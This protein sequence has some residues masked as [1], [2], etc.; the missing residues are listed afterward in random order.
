AS[1]DVE[2]APEAPGWDAETAS[3]KYTSLDDILDGPD[4]LGLLDGANT[5]IFELKHV[6][7]FADRKS[8]EAPD[9]IAQRR[10]CQDFWRYE[11]FF[12]QALSILKT[13]DVLLQRPREGQIKA[14]SLFV[15]RGQL[16][17]VDSVLEGR[18]GV[19]KNA[20]RDG[21]D[22]GENRR[23]HCV[24][25]NGTELDILTLSLAKALY[26]DK[27]SKFV[28]MA[29]NLFSEHVVSV[30]AK[31][32]PTGF[33]YVLETLSTAPEL[34]ELKARRHLVKI[35]YS[36]QPVDKRIA[37]AEKDQTY[38]CAPVRKAAEIACYNLNPQKFEH[39]I[40]GFLNKQKL[41]VK[42][43]NAR[44]GKVYEP[45][46]WFTVSVQTAI[47]VCQHIVDG[48]ISLYR[49]NNVTGEIVKK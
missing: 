33:V 31:D 48:D 38:L 35:G 44:T 20:I 7:S 23:L 30:T 3:W 13:K 5:S 9:E 4:E 14:G 27:H 37:G 8:S 45:K 28:N 46:E 40:H 29:P 18:G 39:L 36:T 10:P 1:A 16:C 2:E 49:M 15:L 22:D 19:G 43:V 32:Q 25:D 47:D 42:L 34:A 26:M 12:Q 6:S 11:R 41:A 24:F 21:K 17:Y